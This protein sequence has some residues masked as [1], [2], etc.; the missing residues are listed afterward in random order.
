MLL[1]GAEGH[2]WERIGNALPARLGLTVPDL[3]D[4]VQK[5]NAVN[6]S[7]KIGGEPAP[8]GQEL[9]WSVR[10]QGRLLTAEEFGDVVVRSDPKGAQ[11]RLKDVARIE[12]GALNY[13]QRGR[14]NGKPAAIIGV[15]QYLTS[16]FLDQMTPT[17]ISISGDTAVVDITDRFTA[18][19]DVADFMGVAL[20]KGESFELK[21][22]GTYTIAGGKFRHIVIEQRA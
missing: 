18:K 3:V 17:A 12:L 16:Q 4:A 19:L 2:A 6:P 13:N 11:V 8:P 14:L 21:L 20:K 9:T 10:A 1:A 7:G 22:R 15:Y 5:Q